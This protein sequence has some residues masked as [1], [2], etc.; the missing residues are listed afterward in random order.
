MGTREQVR[1]AT[2]YL[3]FPVPRHLWAE[4]R[5]AG[6]IRGGAPVPPDPTTPT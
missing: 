4:L 1:Q 5:A 3:E 6:L 2:D